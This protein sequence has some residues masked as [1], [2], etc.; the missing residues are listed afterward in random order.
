MVLGRHE[1]CEVH[2]EDATVSRRHASLRWRDGVWMLLDLG[3]TNGTWVNGRRVTSQTPVRR[4]DLV[5]LGEVQ[6]RLG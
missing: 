2:L 3:S 1:L 4:G 6:V 5:Q